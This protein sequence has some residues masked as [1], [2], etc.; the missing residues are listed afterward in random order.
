MN[1]SVREEQSSLRHASKRRERQS[2][3]CLGPL[4]LLPTLALGRLSSLSL[5]T[6]RVETQF[7]SVTQAVLG[8]EER[9][10]ALCRG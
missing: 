8:E 6:C 2:L 9:N 7:S 10:G 3:P 4:A 5:P 1:S